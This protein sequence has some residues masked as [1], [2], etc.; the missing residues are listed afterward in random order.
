MTSSLSVEEVSYEEDS[1][2]WIGPRLVGD[3]AVHSVELNTVLSI[4][5]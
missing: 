4:T 2:I 5:F 1:N 3:A